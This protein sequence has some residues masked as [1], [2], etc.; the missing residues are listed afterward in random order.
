MLTASA[1]ARWLPKRIG[2]LEQVAGIVAAPRA[3]GNHAIVTGELA[4]DAQPTCR[5]PHAGMEPVHRARRKRQHLRQA[6]VPRD[7]RQLVKDH[8][9]PSVFGPR[10]GDGGNHD[11]R[12]AACRTPSARC[13]RGCEAAGPTR[14]M[15]ILSAHSLSRR[16]HSR[17]CTSVPDAR[18]RTDDASRARVARSADQHARSRR[19]HTDR[20]S[21]ADAREAGAIVLRTDARRIRGLARATAAGA[22][23]SSGSST[24]SR[25][26]HRRAAAAGAVRDHDR[27]RRQQ[28]ATQPGAGARSQC[29]SVQTRWRVAAEA[30]RRRRQLHDSGDRQQR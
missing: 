27:P 4:L 14:R 11:R 5:P 26:R 2:D 20:R 19:P 18:A 24:R 17:S 10:V 15:P 12:T 3:R 7:V 23:W 22:R 1:G 30:R 16:V 25:D 13:A 9:A 8:G 28:R 29:A 6:I 21:A